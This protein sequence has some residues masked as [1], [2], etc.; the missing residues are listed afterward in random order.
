MGSMREAEWKVSS[1]F[2]LL[3]L[4]IQW[5][6]RFVYEVFVHLSGNEVQRLTSASQRKIVN[7]ECIYL[8][9]GQIT[10]D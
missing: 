9:H 2:P 4:S 8:T 7:L 10:S 3:A 6:K 1:G 5:R